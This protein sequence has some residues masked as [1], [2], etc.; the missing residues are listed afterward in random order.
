MYN[1]RKPPRLKAYTFTEIYAQ[2]AAQEPTTV[3]MW[4]KPS[5]LATCRKFLKE[6]LD[7]VCVQLKPEKVEAAIPN[8]GLSTME[9]YT[10]ILMV[11][12][13]SQIGELHHSEVIGEEIYCS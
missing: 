3:V 8:V 1:R 7:V 10:P 4:A 11:Y 5:L 12:R 6:N 2:G 9:D 13:E